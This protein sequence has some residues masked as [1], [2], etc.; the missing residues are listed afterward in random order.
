[1][2]P[3]RERT[4]VDRAR[5]DGS[6]FGELYDFYLPR[7]YG[8][9]LRRVGE[10]SVAEDLTATTFE[11]ALGAVRRSDFRNEAFGG[12]LYR[13]A[14]NAIVDHVRSGRRLVTLGAILDETVGDDGRAE[15]PGRGRGAED[16]SDTARGRLTGDE[17]AVDAFARALDSDQ[18]ARALRGL[19]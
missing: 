9:I 7:L 16:R 11:R 3:A 8:F 6:A 2:D 10:R 15:E 5:A 4:L 17:A 19:P 13:V 1:M 14:A 18:L 12:W